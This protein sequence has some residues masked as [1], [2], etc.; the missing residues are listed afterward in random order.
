[1]GDKR[2]EKLISI[3]KESNVPISGTML[4]EL[5]GVSRQVIVQDIALLRAENKNILSTNKG[6]LLFQPDQ[7]GNVARKVFQV[8]HST[9]E[10]LEELFCIVDLGGKLLNI[11]VEHE[12]YGLIE[13]SLMISNRKDA[14]EF[15]EKLT[16]CGDK[17]LKE[18]TGDM[19]YHTIEADDMDTLTDI[20]EE[21]EN[22][23]FLIKGEL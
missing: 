16:L 21:L 5:L 20:E 9:D 4:A 19:H 15:V 7:V 1:M 17:P 6:Y 14:R 11:S 10:V 13:V 12:I 2:R 22:K 3:L 8:K 23:G 18:L